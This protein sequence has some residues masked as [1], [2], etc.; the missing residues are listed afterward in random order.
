MAQLVGDDE[1]LGGAAAVPLNA[2][3]LLLG[4]ADK[5]N[6]AASRIEAVRGVVDLVIRDGADVKVLD[7]V[8]DGAVAPCVENTSS[9]NCGYGDHVA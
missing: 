1:D 8:T 3:P 7:V 2:K 4:F 6:V 5:I 9:N